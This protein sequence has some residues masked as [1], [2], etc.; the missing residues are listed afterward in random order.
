VRFADAG[1][2]ATFGFGLGVGFACCGRAAGFGALR[3]WTA[4]G[5]GFGFGAGSANV[6]SAGPCDRCGSTSAPTGARSGCSVGG[7]ACAGPVM[8]PATNASANAAIAS[9]EAAAAKGN[10]GS[11]EKMRLSSVEPPV[12]IY[13]P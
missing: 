5:F 9:A 11:R 6:G 2:A 10:R 8:R 4:T 3:R 12:E 13:A 1:E 7:E